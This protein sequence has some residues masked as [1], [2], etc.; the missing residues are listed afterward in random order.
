MYEE[1]ASA[2]VNWWE[3]ASP[4]MCYLPFGLKRR[5][6]DA[7]KPLVEAWIG[8]VELEE[9][10]LYGIRRYARGSRRPYRG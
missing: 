3:T 9:T 7:L 5:W 6:H 2:H 10:D 1:W 8:G 4:E